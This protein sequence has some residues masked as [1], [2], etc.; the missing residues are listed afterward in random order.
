MDEVEN[1]G[2]TQEIAT[3]E[4][5]QQESPPEPQKLV[6]SRHDRNWREM[7]RAN[8]ELLRKTK[9]QEE[10]LQSLLVKQN[11]QPEAP[12][13]PSALEEL[14]QIS[15]TDFVQADHVIRLAEEAREEARRAAREEAEKI[16]Q[17]QEKSRFME[18]L[19]HQFSDFEEVVNP[20]TLALL[21]EN[22]PDLAA[23][24][25]ELKDPYKIGLQSYKYL[26]ATGLHAKAPSI[27]RAKEVDKKIEENAKSVQSP[28]AFDKRPMAQ[29]FKITEAEKKQLYNEMMQY[30]HMA[31]GGY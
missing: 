21:E 8:E 10:L 5:S 16:R 6:E 1:V 29:A 4:T 31:G 19:K 26:K 20:E 3:P 24:I 25:A 15:K 14:S 12:K 9:M 11:Q 2:S 22:D 27:R 28:Q 17:E 13:R 7:R 30:A 23:T 18:K